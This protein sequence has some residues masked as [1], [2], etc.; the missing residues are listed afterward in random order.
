M[1]R[2]NRK[3]KDGLWQVNKYKANFFL[4]G[5]TIYDNQPAWKSMSIYTADELLFSCSQWVKDV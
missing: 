2:R 5:L 4:L 1:Q 3:Y